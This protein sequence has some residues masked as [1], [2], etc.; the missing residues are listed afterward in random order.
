MNIDEDAPTNSAGGGQIAS[1]GQP[2]GSQFG[3]PPSV[4]KKSKVIRRRKPI[5][6][7]SLNPILEGLKLDA[8][9]Q[10][11]RALVNYISSA[12]MRLTNSEDDRGL[13]FLVAAIG[14]LNL[15]DDSQTVA[16]SRRVA[17]MAL[18]VKKR[19]NK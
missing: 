8:N 11:K 3:E 1:I 16:A 17:Q 18:S 6:M 19:N 5:Q 4:P 14:M 12:M 13:L 15:G 9:A 2:A 10:S 7:E